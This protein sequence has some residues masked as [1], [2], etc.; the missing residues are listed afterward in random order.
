MR[1]LGPSAPSSI[2]FPEST[3]MAVGISLENLP[4]MKL[5]SVNLLYY[6]P[7]QSKWVFTRCS[8]QPGYFLGINKQQARNML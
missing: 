2:F 7:L 4:K 3:G 5:D 6:T 1:S 8:K